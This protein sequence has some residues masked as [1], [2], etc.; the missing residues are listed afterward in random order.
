MSLSFYM[1]HHVDQAIT[2]GL[3]TRGIDV[4]T[5]AEDGFAR[6][7][8]VDILHRATELNRV[9]FTYDV[10]FLEIVA[11][12]QSSGQRF[13]GVVY[14]RSPKVS[15]GTSVLDLEL[16]AHTVN[17]AEMENSLLRIPL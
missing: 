7:A 1:D 17:A 13:A 5:A 6:R 10:D 9:L 8:D 4:V 16:I 3:R 11:A 2:A 15:V 14:R 12:W